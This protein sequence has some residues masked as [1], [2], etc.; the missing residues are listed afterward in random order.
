MIGWGLI[1]LGGGASLAVLVWAKLGGYTPDGKFVR[2]RS[3]A[4]RVIIIVSIMAAFLGRAINHNSGLYGG[5]RTWA[6]MDVLLGI[7]IGATLT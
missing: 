3:T 7:V 2:S 5:D 4:A 6:F 1:L